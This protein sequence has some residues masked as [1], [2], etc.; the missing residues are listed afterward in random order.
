MAEYLS[1][2]AARQRS[3]LRL[4]LPPVPGPWAEAAKGLFYVNGVSYV[5]VRQTPGEDNLELV[6]WTGEKNAPQAVYDAEKTR[7]GW[8]EMIFLAERLSAKSSLLPADPVDRA[9]MFGLCF[10]I[11]GEEGF[12][13]LRRLA[14]FREIFAIPTDVMPETHPVR[15]M[16]AGMAHRYGYSE[17]AATSA[18]QRAAAILKLLSTT[19]EKQRSSGS[20]Y[21]IGGDLTAVDV[22]WATFAA[23]IEPLDEEMCAMPAVMRS[24]YTLADPVMLEA[25]SP[26]LLE[27]R[28]FIYE[29]Y[30]EL[31]IDL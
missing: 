9:A 5:P 29:R 15:K 8:A 28:D 6:D 10:A 26:L 27:H 23:L 19:L 4:V 13:W 30:L 3:G 20:H 22:Y 31:P 2:E 12:G 21:F 18:P 17:E 7:T 16:V 1:V 25:A 24:Q 11:C 14:M